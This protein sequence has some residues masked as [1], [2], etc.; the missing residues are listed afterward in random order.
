MTRTKQLPYILIVLNNKYPGKLQQVDA[1]HF[2]KET[3]A[4]LKK[5][6][7]ESGLK[8][9]SGLK[10]DD[11]VIANRALHIYGD[12]AL[13][14]LKESH[15]DT[16]KNFFTVGKTTTK[17]K[18]VVAGSTAPLIE[19]KTK[20]C[21]PNNEKAKKPDEY[22]CNEE[23]GNWIKKSSAKGKAILKKL[24]QA[25][26]VVAQQV[27][28]QV[29]VAGLKPKKDCDPNNPKAKKPDE[30]ICNDE[31]GNWVKR[32]SAKGKDI[33][34]RISVVPPPVPVVDI[35][36]EVVEE[37]AIEEQLLLPFGDG[38][39]PPKITKPKL[40]QQL[41]K[42]REKFGIKKSEL[43]KK[44][45]YI[46]KINQIITKIKEKR[47]TAAPVQ[48]PAVVQQP[49]PPKQRTPK[50]VQLPTSIVPPTEPEELPP[51]GLTN[52]QIA[53]EI[54]KCLGIK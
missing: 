2:D 44:E 21:D 33:L 13:E 47:P 50:P 19:K 11:L 42:Y 22:I 48:V 1:A 37:P 5:K 9:K 38:K 31:T 16:F 34:K 10:K 39:I 8:P 45:D 12:K 41:Q 25:P 28:K 15:L 30:Y 53:A 43:K 35:E 17:E 4:T 40:A 46:A 20:N 51:T 27:P 32:N 7:E 52:E 14:E 23:T 49:A 54:K 36:E 29:P 18:P 26:G 24:S 6:I 3:V